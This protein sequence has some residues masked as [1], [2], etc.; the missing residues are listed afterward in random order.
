MAAQ[1]TQT[2]PARSSIRNAYLVLYNAASAAVWAVILTRT[3]TIFTTRGP[4]A[5]PDGVATLTQWTQTA[6]CL[7]ILHSLLGAAFQ[8]HLRPESPTNN[9]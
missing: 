2:P 9:S 8:P 4:A 1:K 3:I 7:E 5:V 6:A